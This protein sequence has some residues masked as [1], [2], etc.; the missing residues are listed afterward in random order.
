MVNTRMSPTSETV[1]PLVMI[2][3][4]FDFACLERERVTHRQKLLK[5]KE[6]LKKR[7]CI[8]NP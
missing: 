4:K 5:G 6:L 2:A 8:Y 1:L 7:Q 3:Q